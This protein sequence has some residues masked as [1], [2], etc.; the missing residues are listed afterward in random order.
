MTD[1]GNRRPGPWD[2]VR[3]EALPSQPAASRPSNPRDAQALDKGQN[4]AVAIGGTLLFVGFLWWITGSLTIALAV[5]FGLVVHEYGHVLAMNRLGC[6]PARIYIIP[7][8]GGVAKSQRLPT[9]E[10]DGVLISLAGPMFGLLATIPFFILFMATGTPIWILAAFVICMINLINLVPAPPLDGSQAIGPVLSKIS[11]WLERGVMLL[12]GATVV[13]WAMTRGSYIFGA[14][15]ALA[16]FGHLS[17]GIRP[18]YGRALTDGESLKSVGL[19]VVTTLAC[20]GVAVAAVTLLTGDPVNGWLQVL[21]Y[22][23]VIQ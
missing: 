12:I 5:I 13:V 23:G 21:R 19:F 9:S 3:E 6:G 1:Q 2:A 14:F 7:F 22:L 18:I 15:V 20:V 8:L 4:P 10:W 11:P 17:R 16:L